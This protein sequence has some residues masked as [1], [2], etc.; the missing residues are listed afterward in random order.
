[1]AAL[2]IVISAALLSIGYAI[3]HIVSNRKLQNQ[4]AGAKEELERTKEQHKEDIANVI[5]VTKFHF[6]KQRTA[7]EH[8]HGEN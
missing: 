4:L 6:A 8:M 3:G 1:M 7:A 5:T 2:L